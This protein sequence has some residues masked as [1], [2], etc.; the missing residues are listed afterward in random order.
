[1]ISIK[2]KVS[3]LIVMLTL[4]GLSVLQTINIVS[5][6]NNLLDKA[7]ESETNHLKMASLVTETFAQDKIDSLKLMAKHILSLPEA[8]TD[9]NKSMQESL[10]QLLYGFKTGGNY[11]ATY[12]GLA[13]GSMVVSDLGSDEEG[14]LYRIY[15]QGTG[16]SE[17]Y[18]ARTR[19]WYK[20]AIST[21]DP[22]MTPVYQDYVS[23]LPCF[24][25]SIQLVRNG[26]FIGVL[27]IDV[28]L[29]SLQQQFEQMPTRV[30]GLDTE[31][32]VFVSSIRGGLL[33]STVSSKEYH[34]LAAEAGSY[35]PFVYSSL[36]GVQRLGIC[37]QV[38]KNNLRYS[39]CVG[40]AL[41]DILA[42]ANKGLWLSIVVLVV[43]SLV[44]TVI[45]YA[46]L[47]RFLKPIGIIQ[48]GLK[49]FFSFINHG[50]KEPRLIKLD[51]QDELGAM[52]KE[53]NRNILQI[54]K[55]LGED[56]HFVDE[57]LRVA[58]EAQHGN[59]SNIIIARATTPQFNSLKD[60]LNNLL[61]ILDKNLS[62]I[63]YTLNTYS[64]D[65]YTMRTDTAGLEGK[66]LEM[67]TNINRMGASISRILGDQSEVAKK[68]ND[69]VDELFEMVAS[70]VKGSQSQVKSLHEN[71]E[72]VDRINDS[73]QTIAGSMG[74]L[75]QQADEIKSVIHIIQDIANQTN[76]LALNAAIEAA[77]AGEHGR[78][79]AVVADEVR[80]LAERTNKSLGEIENNANALIAS[81]NEMSQSIK[82][83]T[84]GI[85]HISE[86]T[87]HL[88]SVAKENA[89]IANKTNS[90]AQS[91]QSIS[92]DILEDSKKHRF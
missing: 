44:M 9:S 20:T 66:I 63:C 5:S 92:H 67:A 23:K 61:E 77:R 76:L 32:V 6:K 49:D 37:N 58:N 19:I 7:I 51:S 75:T 60:I 54:Q 1:M 69:N 82:E 33:K 83:Q 41:E 17:D 30:Y 43:E 57:V 64:R 80:S 34:R 40:D 86:V 78:G 2:I 22:I 89:A 45:I 52:A 11:L 81:V 91:V 88:E 15:G 53:I 46:V 87:L 50:K 38:D 85:S 65:D 21:N 42:G 47:Y 55:G 10:G 84:Q 48:E 24:T 27:S 72:S 56:K 14:K 71:T 62:G 4:I 36:N 35:N 8:A 29:E 79:F 90:I 31:K 70:L 25:F 68:L 39:I 26:K 59:F 16:V 28:T 74:N 73:M 3:L 18:D 13:D 12:V